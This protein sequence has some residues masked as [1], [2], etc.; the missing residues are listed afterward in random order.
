MDEVVNRIKDELRARLVLAVS[1]DGAKF[2][3]PKNA[4]FG[5]EVGLKYASVAYDID[6]AGKCLALERPTAAV[7][8]LMR[9]V[10]VGV[11][12]TA[13]CLGI[14][15]PT[16]PGDRNWGAMLRKIKNEFDRRDTSRTWKVP[17][18]DVY[19]L[20]VYLLLDA[21]RTVWRNTTMHTDNK[22]TLEEAVDIF[23]TVKSF[24]VGLASRLDENGQP[25]A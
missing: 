18:D 23:G 9:T 20:E 6:E 14:P 12:A 21:V 1:S 19:F 5:S 17:D 16:K 25:L 11:S 3:G 7:F 10:E 13:K 22:Y 15:D 2:Y 24:M 8:H 4:L